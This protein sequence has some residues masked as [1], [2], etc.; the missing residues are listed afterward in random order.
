MTK[1][2]S[3]KFQSACRSVQDRQASPISTR[4]AYSKASTIRPTSRCYPAHYIPPLI[5]TKPKTQPRTL[6]DSSDVPSDLCPYS[7]LS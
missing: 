5:V 6:F 1:A 3:L 7:E 2:V 4:V